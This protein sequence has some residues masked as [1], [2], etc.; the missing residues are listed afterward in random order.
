LTLHLLLWEWNSTR[1]SWNLTLT[2]WNWTQVF[3]FWGED[4]MLIWPIVL[5]IERILELPLVYLIHLP[6]I[7]FETQ[8]HVRSTYKHKR[9]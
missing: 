2:M 9:D 7:A 1:I 3:I 4:L 6:H 5:S 8:I